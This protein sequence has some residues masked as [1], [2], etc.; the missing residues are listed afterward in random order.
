MPHSKKLTSNLFELRIRGRVEV[1]ILYT[2][3]RKDI[4]L[5]HAFK[6]KQQKT[7]REAIGLAKR[8][9]RDWRSRSRKEGKR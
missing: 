3:I 5:L 6:K 8:R 4:Y 7:P 1:R 2:F 9:L